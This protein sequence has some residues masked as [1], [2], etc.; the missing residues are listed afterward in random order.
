MK[1]LTMALGLAAVLA[2]GSLAA[3]LDSEQDS[4]NDGGGGGWDTEEA[5]DLG[6]PKGRGEGDAQ[7]GT[8]AENFVPSNNPTSILDTIW[9]IVIGAHFNGL[10]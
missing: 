7:A 1:K 4:N 2:T 8:A 10:R 9:Q 5:V 3:P 6:G